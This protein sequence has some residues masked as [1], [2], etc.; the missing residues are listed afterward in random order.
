L[1]FC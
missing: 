1:Y